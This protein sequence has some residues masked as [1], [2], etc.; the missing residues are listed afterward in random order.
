MFVGICTLEIY[1]PDS[2]SL[3]AKRQVIKSLKDKI[4]NNYNVSVAE[5]AD[6]DLWQRDVIGVACIGTDKSYINGMLDKIVNFVQE[7]RSAELLNYK[8]EIL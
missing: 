6:H 1:I 7:N 4:R 2:G 8:I 5:I 3:K